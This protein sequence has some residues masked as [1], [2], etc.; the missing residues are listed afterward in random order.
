MRKMLLL[1]L[2]VPLLLLVACSEDSVNAGVVQKEDSVESKKV[3]PFKVTNKNVKML[4]AD[5]LKKK[6]TKDTEKLKKLDIFDD[7]DENKHNIKTVS[8]TL[9][10]N[11]NLTN[12]MVKK[13]M[14]KEGEKLFPKIFED[15][16][17]GRA[18]ITWEFPL[19]DAKGNSS[20]QKVLSIQLERKTADEINWKEFKYKNF[21]IVA[22]N[23]YEH[24]AF[25][26]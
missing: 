3:E 23:Y 10:G 14:L 16:S 5:E 20:F 24:K 6:G 12:N 22:D 11:D 7:V 15:A 19:E 18:L 8:I 25:K 4:I 13:G 26:K 1:L 21:E 9:N 17:V 2:S